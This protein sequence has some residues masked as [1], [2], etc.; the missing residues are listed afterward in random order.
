MSLNPASYVRGPG[1]E[2]FIQTSCFCTKNSAIE[3]NLITQHFYE[4]RN[5]NDVCTD[6][7]K[8]TKPTKMSRLIKTKSELALKANK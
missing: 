2:F 3:S 5:R 8:E 6:T 7:D 1:I 4:K